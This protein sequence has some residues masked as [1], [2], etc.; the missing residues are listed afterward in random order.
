[1][2]VDSD[3]V[4]VLPLDVEDQFQIKR[5]ATTLRQDY[6]HIDALF[7][8]AGVLGDSINTPGPERALQ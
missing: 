7:N 6:K 8:V 5:L 4:T 2:S 1:M 3:C